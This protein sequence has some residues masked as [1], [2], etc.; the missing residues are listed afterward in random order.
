MAD[1]KFEVILEILF[2]KLDNIDIL[3]DEKALTWRIN[4][5]NEA[6]PTIEQV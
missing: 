6:L 1:T 3:F 5:T 4:I 2:L